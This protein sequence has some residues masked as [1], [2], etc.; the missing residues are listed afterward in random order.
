MN[1]SESHLGDLMFYLLIPPVSIFS[2]LVFCLLVYPY[3]YLTLGGSRKRYGGEVLYE[4]CALAFGILTAAGVLGCILGTATMFLIEAEEVWMQLNII[5]ALL[6][7]SA[8]G[9]LFREST[10]IKVLVA[11]E[12]NRLLKNFL[13][14]NEVLTRDFEAFRL[15]YS[16]A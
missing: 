8:I 5:F 14:S 7:S 13:Q 3:F 6:F 16:D 2:A 11:E 10:K 15:K 12:E 4:G 9:S 1:A